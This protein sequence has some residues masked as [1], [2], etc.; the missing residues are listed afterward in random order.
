MNCNT[1]IPSAS[2]QAHFSP[3]Q[4]HYLVANLS[5][6]TL[7]TNIHIDQQLQANQ[8][9]FNMFAKIGPKFNSTSQSSQFNQQGPFARVQKN[10]CQKPVN[11]GSTVNVFQTLLAANIMRSSI[12]NTNVGNANCVNYAP[13]TL[14]NVNMA[15]NLNP[16]ASK[17]P[18]HEREDPFVK[19]KFLSPGF[20]VC[21]IIGY[22]ICNKL[23][24]IFH[25]KKTGQKSAPNNSASTIQNLP[26]SVQKIRS[27]HT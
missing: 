7:N 25:L 19:S 1:A 4:M 3:D 2:S 22:N 16:N 18:I 27:I 15:V 8:Q 5:N 14:N 26:R 17:E 21:S 20:S 6:S 13:F 11:Y 9:L 10:T 12:Q 23:I 24:E